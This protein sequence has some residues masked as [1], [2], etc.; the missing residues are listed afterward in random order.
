MTNLLGPEPTLLPDNHADVEV[1]RQIAEGADATLLAAAN[2]ASSI[3]WAVLAERALGANDNVVAYAYARTGYHRGLDT[4]RKNGWRGTG[5]VPA[6]HQ[7][8]VGVLRAIRALANAAHAIGEGDE[9]A[10]CEQL[11]TDS[12]PTWRT[13]L[14]DADS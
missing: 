14:P 5:P 6:S 3:A 11:L 9:H 7:P 12:D 8:N 10:R 4:L 1:G 13:E 2:P